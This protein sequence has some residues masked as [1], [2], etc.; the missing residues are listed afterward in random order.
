MNNKSLLVSALL[1]GFGMGVGYVVGSKRLK[2]QYVEDLADV[3]DFYAKKLDEM[4]VQ[5]EGFEPERGQRRTL[6]ILENGE[7]AEEMSEEYFN[8]LTGYSS[9]ATTSNEPKG[10][11]RPIVNYSKPPIEIVAREAFRQPEPSPD[12]EESDFYDEAYEAELDARAEDLAQRRHENQSN[13]RPYTINHDE[14]EDLPDNYTRQVLYYYAEDRVLCEDDDSM[15]EEEEAIIG[16]DYEDVLEM[17][18][19]AWVRNDSIMNA[20]QI[21]RIDQS[22]SKSV[23]NVAETPRERDFRILGRRK[24][25]LDN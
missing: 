14:Y 10:K 17:Q 5:P 9:A 20:Y 15:V 24:Q 1:F 16:F 3:K 8:K 13:G 19:T 7:M 12:D 2:A 11:G 21:H 4:G 25:G 22:Y 6:E 23:A 18:T